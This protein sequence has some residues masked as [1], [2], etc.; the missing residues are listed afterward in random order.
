MTRAHVCHILWLRIGRCNGVTN[1]KYVLKIKIK[2]VVRNGLWMLKRDGGIEG[3]VLQHASGLPGQYRHPVS[4]VNIFIEMEGLKKMSCSM[5]VDNQGN[6]DI[7]FQ[8]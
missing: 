2:I 7:Q 3:D 5:L 1:N 4:E 6:T 8:R